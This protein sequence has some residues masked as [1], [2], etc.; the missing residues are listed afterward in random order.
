MTKISPKKI[1]ITKI[2]RKLVLSVLLVGRNY[3]MLMLIL[4]CSFAPKLGGGMKRTYV[5]TFLS[6][7]SFPLVSLRCN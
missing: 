1:Y 4:C 2:L 5:A 3:T 6:I 7:L